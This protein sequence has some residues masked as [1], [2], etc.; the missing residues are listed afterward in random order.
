M[1]MVRT[2]V[3]GVDTHADLHV[4]AAI[5][6][7]GGVLGIEA[8]PADTAGYEGLLSWLVGFG[9]VLRVGVEGTGSYGVGLA[10]LLHTRGV[11][12]VEVD[13]PNRKMRRKVGRSDPTD[14]VSAARAALSGVAAVIPKT[15][16]GPFAKPLLQAGGHPQGVVRRESVR[17]TSRLTPLFSCLRRR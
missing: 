5:D 10:R 3:G 4:A 8:F 15:R 6:G 11:E 7:N 17:P 13:R 16:N 12:V 2:V 9:D 1:S 14:A